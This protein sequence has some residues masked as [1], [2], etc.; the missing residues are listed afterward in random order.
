M[1]RWGPTLGDDVALPTVAGPLIDRA[2]AASPGNPVLRLKRADLSL[3]RFDFAAAASD[4]EAALHADP[5]MPGLRSRLARCRN[6]LGRHGEALAVGT[7]PGDAHALYQHGLAL[8]ALGREQEAERAYRAVLEQE[9]HH[10]HACRKLCR[11]LRRADRNA[12]ML[13]VCEGLA[14]RGAAHAQLFYDWGTAAALTGDIGR[15]R[16]L[17]FNCARVAETALP[18]P[19]GFADIAAFNAVL[20]E[21]I[22]GNPHRLSEFAPG[23][24]ANRGSSRV[25]ALFAGRRP[26]LMRAL[27]QSLQRLVDDYT[28]SPAGPFDPWR[29]ARPAAARLRAWGLIQRGSEHEEW[30]IH[31]GG[32]LSGVY[33]VRVP[34]GISAEGEGPGCIEFGPPRPVARSQPN[35]I[36]SWRYAPREGMLLLAP[37]HY[38]HRTIPSGIDEHRISFAFDVVPDAAP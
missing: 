34:R 3:D 23:E 27:L 17:L 7:E 37:S 28:P 25:E 14:A 16:G 11:L 8:D 5:V 26:D 15:A 4:L 1:T 38:S 6:A 36:P 24:E 19:E 31:R 33:Y 12:E 21:E 2:I 9:P 29:G 18:V 13:A 22:L 10:R 20:T 30:H 32:W 35:L